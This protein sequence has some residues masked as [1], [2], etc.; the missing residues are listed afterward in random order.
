MGQFVGGIRGI[1]EDLVGGCCGERA[2][3]LLTGGK[4]GELGEGLRG[5]WRG[6]GEDLRGGLREFGEDLRGD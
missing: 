2:E 1:F 5:G 6:F 3:E 4:T